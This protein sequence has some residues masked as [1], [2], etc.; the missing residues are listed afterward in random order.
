MSR[1]ESVKLTK[2][3]D[4][5][6]G[7]LKMTLPEIKINGPVRESRLP[8]NINISIPKLD[9]ENLL[10]ELDK[11]GIYAGRGSACTSRAVEPS[12]VLKAIGVEKKYLSG[13][14]RLSMGRQTTKKD[15]DYVLKVFPKIV[16]DLKNRYKNN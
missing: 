3:R 2:L 16:S 14:L 8:N 7:K 4:Y 9:S 6:I 15:L 12:H 5:F 1:N 11:Y 10:L 13:A